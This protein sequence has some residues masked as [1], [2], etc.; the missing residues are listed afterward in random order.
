[1]RLSALQIFIILVI[2]AGICYGTYSATMDLLPDET[3]TVVGNTTN[4]NTNATNQ[5]IGTVYLESEDSNMSIIIT[6][7]TQI[8]KESGGNEVEASMDD[9]QTGAQLDVYTIGKSTNTIPPQITAEKIVVKEPQESWFS[10]L[11]SN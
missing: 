3:G 8:Y 5:T 6:N 10:R 9:L 4:N 7:S 2:L 1:M 11:T